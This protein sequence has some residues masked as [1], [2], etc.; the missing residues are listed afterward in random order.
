VDHDTSVSIRGGFATA[1]GLTGP[2]V[3]ADYPIVSHGYLG[4]PGS[5]VRDGR[6]YRYASNENNN[7][8]GADFSKYSVV[9]VTTRYIRK[10]SYVLMS[11]RL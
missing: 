1:L 9:C 8:L 5:L 6:S 10:A 4:G 3:G 7:A 11:C 2:Q